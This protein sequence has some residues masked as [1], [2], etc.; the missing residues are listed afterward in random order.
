MEYKSYQH[1]E[2]IG[3]ED[4]E[5]VLNGTVY[6]QPK[7]DGTNSCVWFGADGNIHAGSRSRELTLEKDNA[8][9]YETIRSNVGLKLY[10]TAYPERIIYGEW[11]VPHTLKSYMPDA[12]KKFYIFDVYDTDNY[13]YLPYEEY[14]PELAEFI[15]N[16]PN[17][18][19]IPVLK[20]LEN[21]TMEDLTKCLNEN[22]YL[23]IDDKTIGE[24]I[25]LKNYDYKNKYGRTIWGKIV[26]EEFFGTKEKLRSK[27]HE[28]K[29]SDEFEEAIANKYITE[30]VIRKEFAKVMNEV[31]PDGAINRENHGKI[32]GMTLN[33]VYDSFLREDLVDVVKKNK[34]CKID[35]VAMKKHSDKRVKEVL[36][37]E[38]F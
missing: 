38:L 37:E 24:G 20:K 3:R 35:F 30:P 16:E 1:I 29:Q 5:G 11:L 13:R 25:V 22:H 33:A 17:V 21:P 7:I 28:A 4:C 27:N 12:W 9:F 23:M 34:R 31:A 26:A 15:I 19:I 18:E 36:G 10:L 2:K 14:E 8:K 6:V 32:V